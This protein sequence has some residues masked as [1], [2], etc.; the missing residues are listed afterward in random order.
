MHRV[1]YWLLNQVRV[2]F[3]KISAGKL[4]IGS[5]LAIIGMSLF[6]YLL[7]V[8]AAVRRREPIDIGSYMQSPQGEQIK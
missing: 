2:I 6:Y 7:V 4:K 8:E 3:K 5:F 1:L